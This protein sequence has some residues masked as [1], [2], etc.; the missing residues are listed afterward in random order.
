[1]V[2]EQILHFF[3]GLSP[4]KMLFYKE[5]VHKLKFPNNSCID[6]REINNMKKAKTEKTNDTN[7][8]EFDSD[9]ML[10]AKG[11]AVKELIKN[12]ADYD[13]IASLFTRCLEYL[14]KGDHDSAYAILN[15]EMSPS[16][17]LLIEINKFKQNERKNSKEPSSRRIEERRRA[18]TYFSDYTDEELRGMNSLLG[19]VYGK[20]LSNKDIPKEQ[21]KITALVAANAKVS[22]DKMEWELKW[23]REVVIE[24]LYRG[25]RELALIIMVLMTK[26]REYTANGKENVISSFARTILNILNI[27]EI[28]HLEVD[29]LMTILRE[30]D[31]RNGNKSD[32]EY[33]DFIKNYTLQILGQTYTISEPSNINNLLELLE[34]DDY[35]WVKSCSLY[36]IEFIFGRMKKQEIEDDYLYVMEEEY[37]R[38]P[39]S[40]IGI[41]SRLFRDSTMIRK[42]AIEV[43]SFNK[44]ERPFDQSKAHLMY[45]KYHPNT[46]IAEGLKKRALYFFGTSNKE[47]FIS[48]KDA[49]MLDM[50]KCALYHKNAHQLNRTFIDPVRYALP[51]YIPEDFEVLG[52]LDEL[53]ADWIPKTGDKKGGDFSEFIELAK[54][55]VKLATRDLY[56]YMSDTWHT[57]RDELRPLMSNVCVG[58]AISYINPDGTADFNRMAEEQNQI[59]K[60]LLNIYNEL[61]DKLFTVI[62]NSE[63][64]LEGKKLGYDGLEKEIFEMYKNTSDAVPQQ[65]D[66]KYKHYYWLKVLGYLQNNSNEEYK[67]LNVLTKGAVQLEKMVF[68]FVFKDDADKYRNPLREYIIQKAQKTG[69]IS[70]EID[71]ASAVSKACTAIK[72]TEETRR[73]VQDTIKEIIEGSPGYPSIDYIDENPVIAVL[74]EMML[75]SGYGNIKSR[76]FIGEYD[77][78][79]TNEELIKY[80]GLD[81]LYHLCEQI[82]EEYLVVE[83]LLINQKYLIQPMIE[84]LLT[85]DYGYTLSKIHSIKSTVF[86]NDALMEVVPPPIK[87]GITGW[88][89]IQAICR[90]N[91]DLREPKEI[92]YP[93]IIDRPFLE[94]LAEA[95]MKN[96]EEIELSPQV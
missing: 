69:I 91:E 51:K 19:Y 61:I 31:N 85:K 23:V 53:M 5:V 24:S 41:A 71:I 18:L 94:A 15:N 13:N 46:N 86:D 32:D 96:S 29:E 36:E 14:E 77:P 79:R 34:V 52:V 6:N 93:W 66:L 87:R 17:E 83:E 80:L 45:A 84:D 10:L 43:L 58:L 26:R 68:E 63:Y 3:A 42:E 55:D 56:I 48:K 2:V 54:K 95:Y 33:S 90:I 27:Q 4:T 64:D 62:R 37:I 74:Q 22:K 72:M 8:E 40:I 57:G 81:C 70:P 89:T 12:D 38:S 28:S 78:N 60:M 21:R 67:Y 9:A 11:K 88:N 30:C 73:Q 1:L 7:Q 16:K 76:M 75:E 20:D 65:E 82:D 39:Q 92:Y 35:L 49:F 25:L 44:W 47:D 50:M 59:Y